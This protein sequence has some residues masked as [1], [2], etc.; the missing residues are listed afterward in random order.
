MQILDGNGDLGS[1][2]GGWRSEMKDMVLCCICRVGVEV[3][4]GC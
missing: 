1:I 2:F 4:V 3:R